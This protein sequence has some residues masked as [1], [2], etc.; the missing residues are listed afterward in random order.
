MPLNKRKLGGKYEQIAADFLERMGYNIICRNFRTRTGEADI[1]AWDHGT[2]VFAEVKY[3]RN[4]DYG[5]PAESV[6]ARKQ[7]KIIAVSKF[8]VTYYR[9]GY[10]GRPIRYDV[11]EIVGD[12]IRVLKGCFGADGSM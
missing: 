10:G 4:L 1:V 2:L 8:F 3:R 11:V 7:Q 5:S 12:K 9:P 6:D